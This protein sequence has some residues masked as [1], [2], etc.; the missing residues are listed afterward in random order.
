MAVRE[1]GTGRPV[2]LL[3]GW[4]CHGGFFHPQMEALAGKLH[5]LAPDLPG[6]GKARPASPLSIESAADRGADLIA[7][8]GLRDVVLV[9]W[10]MGAA[11]AWSL[12]E[13]H[14]D[15][16]IAGLVTVDMTPRVLNDATWSLGTGDGLTEA[17]NKR[18]VE[19][20]PTD[21][22]R[23]ADHIARTIFAAD[24]AVPQAQYD[25]VRREVGTADPDAMAAM[26]QSLV[27]QD[28]RALLP[29]LSLPTLVLHGRQSQIYRSAVAEW[30]AQQ[31][32]RPELVIMEDVGHAPHLE[33]PEA[34]NAALL[35]FCR[36][37]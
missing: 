27:E 22:P 17:R 10:S 32:Q 24:H 4:T 28:F 5:L 33:R 3:H 18:V 16:R 1:V 20:M 23:F 8:K 11:V 25:W 15:A 19:A 26:W 14:G 36:R 29:R 34:F 21:W 6:H 12:L 30:Q 13:R 35:N 7:E 9:G 31:L 2:V 37:L